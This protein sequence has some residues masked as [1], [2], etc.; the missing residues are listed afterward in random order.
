MG[1]LLPAVQSAREAAR[2]SQ[3]LN[4]LKQMQLAWVMYADDAEGRLVPNNPLGIDPV[5]GK[6]GSGWCDG[7]LDFN[8]GNTDNT[9]TALLLE[10][11]LEPV[12]NFCERGFGA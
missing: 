2:R 7:W 10:S 9:N 1:L 12:I 5:T 3:C 6:K 11:G 4:N 8:A